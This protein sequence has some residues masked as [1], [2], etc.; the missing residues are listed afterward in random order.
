M[1]VINDDIFV[2]SG[3]MSEAQIQAFLVDHGSYLANYTVPSED[4][5]SAVYRFWNTNGA[6]FYTASE[7]ERDN[8]NKTLGYAYRFEGTAYPLNYNSG[9]NTSPLYRFYNKTNNTHFYTCL[10]YT[11]PSPRD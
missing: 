8:I 7:T 1:N 3:T 11:S 10:L 6:H 2:N 4:T 9:R 5:N